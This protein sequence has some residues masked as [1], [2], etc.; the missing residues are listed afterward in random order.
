MIVVLGGMRSGS[1][2]LAKVLHQLGV[3]MGAAMAMP[4]PCIPQEDYEDALL[5]TMV[6][7][8][9]TAGELG[10]YIESRRTQY[11][12]DRKQYDLVQDF[13]VKVVALSLHWNAWCEA[14]EAQGEPLRVIRAERPEADMDAS[15]VRCSKAL[16]PKHRDAWL[17]RMRGIQER[18]LKALAPIRVDLVI[19][20]DEHQARPYEVREQLR[21][22]LAE[23]V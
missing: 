22:W 19:D 5:G 21:A 2:A 23:G 9:P 1:S 10:F 18:I 8:A 13:G 12:L 14:A 15:L 16:A 7:G 6:L 3:T 17:A 4:I 20:H 11:Q